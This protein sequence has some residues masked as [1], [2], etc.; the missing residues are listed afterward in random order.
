[1]HL[2]WFKKTTLLTKENSNTYGKC[3]SIFSHCILLRIAHLHFYFVWFFFTMSAFWWFLFWADVFLTWSTLLR[4]QMNLQWDLFSFIGN[5]NWREDA[6]SPKFA[7][8]SMCFEGS[9]KST[10]GDRGVSEKTGNW[11]P[12]H[13]FYSYIDWR[14][15]SIL[16][17]SAI[18]DTK[19]KY[20]VIL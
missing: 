13:F 2:C 3:W 12:D 15:I 11:E 16:P 17:M 8:H 14:I 7:D 4:R 18:G 6:L 9:L 20:H 10:A 19:E 5:Y 1:M